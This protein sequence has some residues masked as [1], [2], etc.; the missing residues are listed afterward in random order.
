MLAEPSR[1]LC[2]NSD[3]VALEVKDE[4]ALGNLEW[5]ARVE[6]VGV[7]GLD[8]SDKL[9]RDPPEE[10]AQTMLSSHDDCGAAFRSATNLGR[11]SGRKSFMIIVTVLMRCG[12]AL[13]MACARLPALL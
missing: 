3:E 10:C 5:P 4:L 7:G 2:S 13:L 12:T 8:T 9:E 6:N 11:L 1:S